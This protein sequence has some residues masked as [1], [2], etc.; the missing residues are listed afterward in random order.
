MSKTYQYF[1]IP[2]DLVATSPLP[3]YTVYYATWSTKPP[4]LEPGMA[5]PFVVGVTDSEI[6]AGSVALGAISKDPPPPPP[7]P[8]TGMS[9]YQSSINLWLQSTRSV[10]E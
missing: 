8:A 5:P 10:D 7:P 6:P 2:Y 1:K 9:D 4:V 3:P